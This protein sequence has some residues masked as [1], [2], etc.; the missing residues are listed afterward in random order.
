[1][2]LTHAVNGSDRSGLARLLPV[3]LAFSVWHGVPGRVQ[4]ETDCAQA[5]SIIRDASQRSTD[6]A[7]ITQALDAYT[8]AVTLCPGMA[9]AHYNR[10][11][12]LVRNRNYDEG[13]ISLQ[14]ASELKPQPQFRA[15]LATAYLEQGKLSEAREHFEK[16]LESDSRSVKALQGLSVIAEK[17]GDSERAFSLL[18]RAYAAAPSD[19]ITLF[20]L[21]VLKEKRGMADE[22]IE[23][24]EKAIEIDRRHELATTRLAALYLQAGRPADAQRLTSFILEINP[25][26]LDA[27]KL[28]A[29]L[30]SEA[31]DRGK[32]VL[33]LKRALEVE[34]GNE[35]TLVSLATLLIDQHAAD[36]ALRILAQGAAR[37]PQSAVIA[38]LSGQAQMALGNFA[39]AEEGFKKALS[40]NALDAEAHYNYALLLERVGRNDEAAE[41][42]Q[43]AIRLKPELEQLR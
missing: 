7:D 28:N 38:Q 25:K 29:A 42:R 5:A 39:A 4:A 32:A 40:L 33:S 10:G 20:N 34:P 43:A 2:R 11:I 12:M 1:M 23:L 30:Q 31:D 36:E 19:L 14:K 6:P 18:E 8:R 26:N 16:L 17:Q 21:A 22:A 15:A 24:Y 3:L 27:L 13:I 9:E 35:Q 41:H 37:L